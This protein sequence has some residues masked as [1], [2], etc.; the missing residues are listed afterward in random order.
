MENPL[1]DLALGSI[2]CG[3]ALWWPLPRFK[4]ATILHALVWII[5]VV[6]WSY[7]IFFSSNLTPHQ[8]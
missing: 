1:I 7:P 5:A 8:P 6:L 4:Y 3:F 2:M